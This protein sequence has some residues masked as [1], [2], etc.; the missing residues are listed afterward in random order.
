MKAET[1][2]KCPATKAEK[3]TAAAN[4]GEQGY[5]NGNGRDGSSSRTSRGS[6]ASPAV[7]ILD[8]LPPELRE[9]KFLLF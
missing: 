1:L 4:M 8:L 5:P 6:M 9:N 3:S 2:R 7:F